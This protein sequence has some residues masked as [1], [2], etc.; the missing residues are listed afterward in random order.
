[1]FFFYYLAICNDIKY[2]AVR[3]EVSVFEAWE[4]IFFSILSAYLLRIKSLLDLL[5]RSECFGLRCRISRDGFIASF[6]RTVAQMTH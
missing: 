5:I 2:D 4:I 1:M 3:S 6:P